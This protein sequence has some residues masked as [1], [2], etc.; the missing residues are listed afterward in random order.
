MPVVDNLYWYNSRT[1]DLTRY[2]TDAPPSWT[3]KAKIS[4]VLLLHYTFLFQLLPEKVH[5]KSHTA[6]WIVLEG[7]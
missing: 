1:G 5:N 3:V 4:R 2:L 7:T 6:S